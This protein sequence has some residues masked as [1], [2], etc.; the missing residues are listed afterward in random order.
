MIRLLFVGTKNMYRSRF[1]EIYLNHRALKENLPVTA[2][3]VGLKTDPSNTKLDKEVTK[4]LEELEITV[5]TDRT[6]TQVKKFH[7]ENFDQVISIDESEHREIMRKEFPLWEN[8]ISYWMVHNR[9][10][11]APSKALSKIKAILD[12]YIEQEILAYN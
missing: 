12:H 7:F 4:I 5:D 3:S 1:A 6:P 9:E 11:T 2:Y 8:K 10:A